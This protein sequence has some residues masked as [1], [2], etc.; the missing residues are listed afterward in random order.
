MEDVSRVLEV[1][2]EAAGAQGWIHRYRNESGMQAPEEAGDEFDRVGK[3][4]GAAIA[5]R[6]PAA[7]QRCAEARRGGEQLGKGQN[8]V[9]ALIAERVSVRRVSAR[10]AP[11]RAGW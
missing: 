8:P 11:Q 10:G 3:K 5:S 6:Q 7:L 9:A 4:G 1:V 2:A